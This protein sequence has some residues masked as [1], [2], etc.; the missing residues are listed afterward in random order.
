M[1]FL[2][3]LIKNNNFREMFY[4]ILAVLFLIKFI[5]FD[6]HNQELCDG[7]LAFQCYL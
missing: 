2:N 7:L 6:L 3:N 4:S 1:D 5:V